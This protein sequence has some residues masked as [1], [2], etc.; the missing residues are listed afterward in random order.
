MIIWVESGQIMY[1]YQDGTSAKKYDGYKTM[2]AYYHECHKN[3]RVSNAQLVEHTGVMVHCGAFSYAE[4]LRGKHVFAHIIGVTGTLKTLSSAEKTII[5]QVFGIER[6]SYMPSAYGRNKLAFRKND[7]VKVEEG[8][9][10]HKE[11]LEEMNRRWRNDQPV[12]VFFNDMPALEAFKESLSAEMKTALS[13][14]SETSGATVSERDTEIQRA[15]SKGQIT[16]LTRALGR[17]T[18]FYLL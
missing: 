15:T 14:M 4:M 3:H 18:D 9:D 5:H 10:Y 1:R 11:L 6:Y 16:L 13:V 17:G 2:W 12:M 8:A 7:G